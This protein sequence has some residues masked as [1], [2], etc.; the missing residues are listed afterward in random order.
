MKKNIFILLLLP[1]FSQA[2]TASN[3][4]VQVCKDRGSILFLNN[5]ESDFNSTVKGSFSY[6]SFEN[7]QA[8][9]V[10]F[11]PSVGTKLLY[12]SNENLKLKLYPTNKVSS[13]TVS[14]IVNGEENCSSNIPVVFNLNFQNQ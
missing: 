7:K 14:V 11:E 8:I 4:Q 13:Q 10:K 1:L 6:V 5:L 2:N 9:Y 3:Q 12:G